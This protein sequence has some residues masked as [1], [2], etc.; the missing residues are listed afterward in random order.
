MR[1]RAY[2]KASFT[3]AGS[4]DNVP[5]GAWYLQGVSASHT[6]SYARK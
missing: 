6:R 5:A 4:L 3:P 1:E 2:G